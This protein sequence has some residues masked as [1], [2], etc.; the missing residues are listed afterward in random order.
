MCHHHTSL[1][2]THASVLAESRVLSVLMLSFLFPSCVQSWLVKT[3]FPSS[4]LKRWPVSAYLLPLPT[5]YWSFSWRFCALSLLGLTGRPMRGWQTGRSAIDHAATVILTHR[6]LPSTREWDRKTFT[7]LVDEMSCNL[8]GTMSNAVM[9]RCN[10]SFSA[11][12]GSK[13]QMH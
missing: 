1:T 3:P 13:Q 11:A 8:C 7:L 10:I 2:P 9:E 6:W 5:T 4:H 12:V